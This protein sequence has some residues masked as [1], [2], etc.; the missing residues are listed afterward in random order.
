MK[1][2][3]G[4]LVSVSVFFFF[5]NFIW[6]KS[7]FSFNIFWY[8]QTFLNFMKLKTMNPGIYAQFWFFNTLFGIS[9]CITFCV[10]LFKKNLS[11][12]N[13]PNFIVWFPLLNKISGNM[14][15]ITVCFPSF[16][17][18]NFEIYIKLSSQV[19]FLYDQKAKTK[20]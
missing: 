13:R 16:D 7:R 17:V 2:E 1:I 8:F 5:F 3:A 18:I 19:V 10:C 9:F 4:R 12:I 14:F 11:F 6:G 15:V 20:I